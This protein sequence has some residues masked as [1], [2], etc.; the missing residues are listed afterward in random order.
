MTLPGSAPRRSR[1]WFLGASATAAGFVVLRCGGGASNPPAGTPDP[2][3]TP[4]GSTATLPPGIT[5]TPTPAGDPSLVMTG[6]VLGDGQF[7]PHRTQVGT[8]QGQQAFVYSRLL[9][10][11]DQ[12]QGL[13]K[14][15]LAVDLPEQPD[16]L[17]YVFELNPA[18]RWHD[19]DPLNGR[20]LTADDVVYS[21]DRQR[22]G[23][24]SVFVRKARWLAIDTI[25]AL[26]SHTLAITTAAPMAPMIS[27]LADAN[28]F[29]VAPEVES[30]GFSL[31]P[32]GQIGSGPYQWVEWD[33]FN[34][35]SVRANENWHGGTPRLAGITVRQP[36]DTPQV[37]AALR[38]KD[39]DAAFVGRL[40]ADSLKRAVPDLVESHVG[41]ALFFGMRFGTATPPF[42]DI[43]VRTAL[44]IAMDRQDMVEQFFQGSGDGSAWVSWPVTQWAMSSSDL[45]QKPGH[46]LGSGGRDQDIRD[47]RQLIEAY[48]ADGNEFAGPLTL[49]VEQTSEQILSLGSFMARHVFEALGT[50]VTVEPRPVEELA[51]LLLDPQQQLPWVA[52]PDSGWLDLD[53]WLYPYFHSA[54]AQNSFALRNPDLDA[55]IEAQ[56]SEFDAATRHQ[57]GLQIQEQLL[58]V[59]AGVNLVSERV[60]SLQRPYVHAFPLD[61]MDGYQDR[62]AEC[63]IDVTD[64]TF[65]GR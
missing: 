61:V 43:R 12:A 27:W 63:W 29:I 14:P 59:N 32:R 37:E 50:E 18:A 28:A 36:F 53:D 1:R 16:E 19:V 34:F 46:R 41:N 38:V 5:V 49:Y 39:L 42:N 55:L 3:Q 40:T 64:P 23:D 9:T 8:I 22:L 7:D 52:G 51:A 17:T 26:D 45:S 20:P 54:G 60:V 44:S 24:R 31:E 57:L 47:A 11:Q 33:E 21:F 35:A 65:R 6:F 15:D 58:L 4:G 56:R 25:E 2:F 48:R 10:F 62:F 13:L 30:T